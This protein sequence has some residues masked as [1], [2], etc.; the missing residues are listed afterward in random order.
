MKHS[1]VYWGA[2]FHIPAGILYP[3]SPLAHTP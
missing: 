1:E 3:P 2:R